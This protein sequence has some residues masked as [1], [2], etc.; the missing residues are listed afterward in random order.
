MDVYSRPYGGVQKLLDFV[1]LCKVL[2]MCPR[3]VLSLNMQSPNKSRRI[4]GRVVC[5]SKGKCLYLLLGR[6]I[7]YAILN[8]HDGLLGF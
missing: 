6:Q 1:P 8:F 7:L 4:I 5:L 3:H 2:K